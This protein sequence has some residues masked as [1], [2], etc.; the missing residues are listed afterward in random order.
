MS[1]FTLVCPC[2]FGTEAVLKREIYDLGYDTGDVTDGRV[3][4]FGDEEAIVR[5]NMC[6]RSAERVLL[7][8]GKFTARSF[9]ELFEGIKSLPWED[10]LPGDAA[11]WVTKAAGVR[12]KLFSSSDIQSVAKKAMV[13]RMKTKYGLEVFPEDGEKYPVRI[14]IRNDEVEVTLDTSGDSLHKRGYRILHGGAPISETLAASLI[15]LTPWKKDRILADPFCGSG[16]FLIE[17]A[18]MAANIAP[19][20]NRDFTAKKWTNII[21]AGMWKEIRAELMD[22]IDMPDPWDVDL[23][24]FDADPEILRAAGANARAAGVADMIHFKTCNAADFSHSKKYGFVITNPPYGERLE[25]MDTLPGIYMGISQ[26][27]ERMPTWSFY[28]ITAWDETGSVIRRKP[29]KIRKLYNGMIRTGYY[30]YPG[31]KPPK[32]NIT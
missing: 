10:F 16:T 17:A 5:A 21:P 28:I 7:M 30:M 32:R 13:E 6:L 22:E 15:M 26:V 4:F 27:M 3:S 14:F 25:D 12:S 8:V 31:E 9:E 18:M 2:H 11:F 1:D 24:G 23:Q 20:L 19:G 29:Q